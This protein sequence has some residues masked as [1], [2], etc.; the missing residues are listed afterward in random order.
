MT[1]PLVEDVLSGRLLKFRN[2]PPVRQSLAQLLNEGGTRLRERPSAS[3]IGDYVAQGIAEVTRIVDISAQDCWREKF[4]RLGMQWEDG[5]ARNVLFMEEK[6]IHLAGGWVDAAPG[7]RTRNRAMTGYEHILTVYVPFAA[8][9]YPMTFAFSKEAEMK[10]W[11][12]R[13]A[14]ACNDE[15]V[16]R[17][18]GLGRLR[19]AL[20]S[21]AGRREEGTC[22]EVSHSGYSVR[23]APVI[24]LPVEVRDVP[25][26]QNNPN[27]YVE[28]S[29]WS[30]DRGTPVKGLEVHCPFYEIE[31]L[32]SQIVTYETPLDAAGTDSETVEI[33]S[34]FRA[35]YGIAIV[36]L[37]TVPLG[38]L[39]LR[40][41]PFFCIHS[42]RPLAGDTS[43]TGRGSDRVGSGWTWAISM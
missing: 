13:L 26:I 32:E 24:D 37:W 14:E 25:I 18:R 10:R 16:A 15:L 3:G 35:T 41:F 20:L 31:R 39:S 28:L 1:E 8:Y 40:V 42:W 36:V 33:R 17:D 38:S 19:V 29:I 43:S 12:D 7:Q 4:V 6:V 5:K 9:K 27:A 22:L 34:V 30:V 2:K 23:S 21:V 11:A